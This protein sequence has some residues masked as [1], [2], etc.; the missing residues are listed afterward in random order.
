MI[1]PALQMADDERQVGMQ[2]GNSL[3]RLP[4]AGDLFNSAATNA[5]ALVNAYQVPRDLGANV[6]QAMAKIPGDAYRGMQAHLT[7]QIPLTGERD[8]EGAAHS[9][10]AL[11]GAGLMSPLAGRAL[12]GVAATSKPASFVSGLRRMFGAEKAPT[13]S[14]KGYMLGDVKDVT[15]FGEQQ[16]LY[17]PIMKDG[18]II[19]D[20]MYRIDDVGGDKKLHVYWIVAGKNG[21]TANTLGPAA[22][23]DLSR[24][25]RTQHPEL[26]RVGG[27]RISGARQKS[28]ADKNMETVLRSDQSIAVPAPGTSG[29]V[30][31]E[32]DMQ[33]LQGN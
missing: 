28:G 17:R 11:S 1:D 32:E 3:S 27:E 8:R 21:G 15:P 20:I 19:G 6:L 4:S 16:K 10:N 25:L 33:K 18:E 24:Q 12:Q 9:L 29:I 22:V 30:V 13:G 26:K 23:R 31:S 2:G 7:G 14:A 5:L